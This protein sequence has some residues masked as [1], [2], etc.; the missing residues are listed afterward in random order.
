MSWNSSG[1]RGR[2][3]LGALVLLT[4]A[5]L[6]WPITRITMPAADW[7]SGAGVGEQ[8]RWVDAGERVASRI[9]LAALALSV[10]GR[11]RLILPIALACVGTGLFWIY[12]NMP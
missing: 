1:W 11:P 8:L 10:F 4:F 12:S 2:V 6:L 5:I 7:S 3:T 9:L